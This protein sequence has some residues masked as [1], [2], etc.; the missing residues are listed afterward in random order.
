[1]TTLGTSRPRPA[2]PA[3]ATS[4]VFSPRLNSSSV[5]SR[6]TWSMAAWMAAQ[7]YPFV[8]RSWKSLSHLSWLCT[9]T[10]MEPRSNQTPRSCSSRM[11]LSPSSCTSAICRMFSDATDLPPTVTSSGNL[12]TCFARRS[13]ALGNVALKSSV[14]RS[15]RTWPRIM[16]ICGSKPMSNM[17]SASSMTTKV[18][19]SKDTRRPACIVRMS[20]MRPGVHTTTSAPRF[21]FA[22]CSFTPAPP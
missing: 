18:T 21:R 8:T 17:R 14:C 15:G 7:G 20:I 9:N 16:R 19:R 13:T 11:N 6:S 10:M 2:T 1:M 5:V 3:V 4:S 12:S 22:I